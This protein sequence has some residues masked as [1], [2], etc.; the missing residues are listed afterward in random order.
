M[1]VI[2]ASRLV[3]SKVKVEIL[4]EIEDSTDTQGVAYVNLELEGA[5]A[6]K[7]GWTLYRAGQESLSKTMG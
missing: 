2:R 6:E 4:L 1:K 5:L 7:L 3:V